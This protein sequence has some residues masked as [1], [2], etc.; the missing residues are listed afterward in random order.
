[1]RHR[2]SQNTPDRH[3][4]LRATQTR[5]STCGARFLAQTQDDTAVQALAQRMWITTTR[6]SSS[7]DTVETRSDAR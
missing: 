4:K 2:F 3:D 7:A 6:G 1:M 5:R